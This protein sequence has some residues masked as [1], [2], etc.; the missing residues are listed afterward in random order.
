MGRHLGMFTDKPQAD[1]AHQWQQ[2]EWQSEQ[3]AKSVH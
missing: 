2:V 3:A 1:V